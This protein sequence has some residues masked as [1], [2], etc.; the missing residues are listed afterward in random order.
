M[1]I[2]VFVIPL[3]ILFV[4]WYLSFSATRLDRLHQ[5]VDEHSPQGHAG[6]PENDD[7]GVVARLVDLVRLRSRVGEHQQRHRHLP[8]AREH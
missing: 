1:E 5:R 6:L 2:P 8:R 3:L 4:I 7:V